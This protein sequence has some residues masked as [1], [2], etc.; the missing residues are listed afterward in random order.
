MRAKKTRVYEVTTH[1]VHLA[2]AVSLEDGDCVGDLLAEPAISSPHAQRQF[3]V[4]VHL[5]QP[6]CVREVQQE[7]VTKYASK[8]FP[9]MSVTDSS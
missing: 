3:V 4:P 7:A 8:S 1:L 6:N 2:G 9:Q 5:T